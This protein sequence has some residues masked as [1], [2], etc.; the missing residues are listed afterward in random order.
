MNE[1]I[2][3]FGLGQQNYGIGIEEVAEISHVPSI[4]PLPAQNKIEGIV[5]VRGNIH[6]VISLRKVLGLESKEIDANSKLI[7]LRG[8]K[9]ALL[10]D[11]VS[12]MAS[13]PENNKQNMDSISVF[14]TNKSISYVAEWNDTLISVI[15]IHAMLENNQAVSAS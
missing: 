11:D 5:D 15:D 2:I 7:L 12:T 1:Q 10:A 4:T 3:I 13:I 9:I 8:G 14:G 6:S